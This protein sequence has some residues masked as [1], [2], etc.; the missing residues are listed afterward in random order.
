M[1]PLTVTQLTAWPLEEWGPLQ[2][3]TNDRID[4]NSHSWTGAAHWGRGLAVVPTK[5]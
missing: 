4:F 3:L 2:T 5:V 1:G